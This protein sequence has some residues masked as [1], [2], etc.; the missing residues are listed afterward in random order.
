MRMITSRGQIW[1]LN[2]G[3]KKRKL[4]GFTG[5]SQKR[6]NGDIKGRGFPM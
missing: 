6:I 5:E 1:N 2:P 4:N 3:E